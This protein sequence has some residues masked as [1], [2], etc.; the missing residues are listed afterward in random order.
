M[1]LNS[2]G[3]LL[4]SFLY[5]FSAYLFP[6]VIVILGGR[7]FFYIL[8]HDTIA[9]N[10]NSFFAVSQFSVIEWVIMLTISYVVGMLI[11]GLMFIL[12]SI[13]SPYL[14]YI[15]RPYGIYR[16]LRIKNPK[17]I[18]LS[19]KD[20]TINLIIKKLEI[21]ASIFKDD[22]TLYKNVNL[23]GSLI[24]YYMTEVGHSGKPIGRYYERI[25][26]TQNMALVLLVFGS[27][28]IFLL[29]DE[30]LYKRLIVFGILFIIIFVLLLYCRV[31]ALWRAEMMLRRF[32][33]VAT[34][35]SDN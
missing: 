12:I 32:H 22:E 15:S 18:L 21:P 26:M 9:A 10:Y 13:Q 33:V 30:L 6:G 1:G 17:D 14:R 5:E 31:Q 20:Q 11:A 7:Q 2:I 3:G 24:S 16:I 23:I 29:P 27:L 4:D 8:S 19:V 34:L 35:S 25:A 28:Q